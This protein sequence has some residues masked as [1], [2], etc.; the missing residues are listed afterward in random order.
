MLKLI[1][2]LAL[3]STPVF[4]PTVASAQVMTMEERDAYFE[5]CRTEYVRRGFGN[6]D[7]AVA[8]C[9]PKAYGNDSGGYTP[10][11][12]PVCGPTAPY[13]CTQPD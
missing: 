13:T 11:P 5:A 6:D 3:V 1:S 10:P 9:Y 12:Q 4:V 2:A 8:Y 7:A